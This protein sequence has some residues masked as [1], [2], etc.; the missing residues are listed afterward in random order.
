MADCFDWRT[1][2]SAIK[3]WQVQ[4]EH[5]RGCRNGS[6]ARACNDQATST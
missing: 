4:Q 3:Q 1:K 5:M 6:D 2:Q